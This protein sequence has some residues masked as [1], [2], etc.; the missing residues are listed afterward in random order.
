MG[1]KPEGQ[2]ASGSGLTTYPGGAGGCGK[3][4]KCMFKFAKCT[5]CGRGERGLSIEQDVPDSLV[6]SSERKRTSDAFLQPHRS[7]VRKR[8][9]TI[10]SGVHDASM[11]V[12]APDGS[13]NHQRSS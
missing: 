9:Y 11:Q 4:G 13:A 5:K 3:G 1:Q 2:L 6:R 12:V 7:S 10:A 8:T